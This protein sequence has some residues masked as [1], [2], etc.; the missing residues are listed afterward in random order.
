MSRS[1]RRQRGGRS[2][3][4]SHL[5]T[6]SFVLP[7]GTIARMKPISQREWTE[8]SSV[9]I[10]SPQRGLKHLVTKAFLVGGCR[11]TIRRLE[12]WLSLEDVAALTTITAEV[13]EPRLDEAM[14]E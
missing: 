1:K 11:L 10:K 8:I 4:P 13:F 2:L 12:N 7:S 9:S 3:K 5:P 14:S 6:R